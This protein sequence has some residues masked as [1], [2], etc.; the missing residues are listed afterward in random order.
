MNAVPSHLSHCHDTKVVESCPSFSFKMQK[1]TYFGTV[2]AII[3]PR[4]RLHLNP[5]KRFLFIL[6]SKSLILVHGNRSQF[7]LQHRQKVFL[8]LSLTALI[9]D[10]N[11][12]QPYMLQ[13]Q[14]IC[15]TGTN[16]C[17]TTPQHNF[18]AH[19]VDFFSDVN[20]DFLCSN[21][22]L[23]QKDISNKWLKAP[24]TL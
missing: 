5:T 4:D 13:W 18:K 6:L 16:N 20:G 10:V 12:L 14:V 8:S 1:E 7:F 19:K 11:G 17:S 9:D 22:H 21:C 15:Y 2:C 23:A 24:R 3:Q